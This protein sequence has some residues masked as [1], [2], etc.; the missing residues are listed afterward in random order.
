R[1]L[2]HLSNLW[3]LQN[4]GHAAVVALG[5]SFADNLAEAKLQQYVPGFA[6]GSI[7]MTT[8][9]DDL[10]DSEPDALYICIP[11][12]LHS[13]QVGR[14]AQAGIHLFVEKPMSLFLDEAVEMEQAI[15]QAGILAAVGF[16]QRY[17]V[18]HDTVRDFL[19]DKRVVMTT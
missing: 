6:T 12:N 18:R 3:R 9:F 2:Q 5:D 14:A 16:Q 13:G 11:P 19:A 1:G 8:D 10:L 17:D 7:R 15:R 4:E